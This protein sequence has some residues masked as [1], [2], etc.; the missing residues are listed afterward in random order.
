MRLRREGRELEPKVCARPLSSAW[1]LYGP[2]HRVMV[3]ADVFALEVAQ[4]DRCR[5]G[6]ILAP[7]RYI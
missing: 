6:A 2:S 5:G 4:L 7:A 3:F 1:G